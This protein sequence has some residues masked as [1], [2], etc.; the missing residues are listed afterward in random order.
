MQGRDRHLRV[1]RGLSGGWVAFW[2]Q[3]AGGRGQG[4]VGAPLVMASEAGAEALGTSR[5]GLGARVWGLRGGGAFLIGTLIVVS[6]IPTAANVGTLNIVEVIK[7][8][9]GHL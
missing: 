2:A 3:V 7:I 5:A 6:S 9:V 4:S 8:T 1:F